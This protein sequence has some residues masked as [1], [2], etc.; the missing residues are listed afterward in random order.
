MIEKP[1]WVNIEN[2]NKLFYVSAI[3]P[4][5]AGAIKKRYLPAGKQVANSVLPC[6]PAG[7]KRPN[8]K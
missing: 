7:R 4:S 8:Q 5:G 1:K 6:L 3:T 2:I